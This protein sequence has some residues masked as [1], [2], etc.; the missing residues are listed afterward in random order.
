MI[1]RKIKSVKRYK[2]FS[3]FQWDKFCKN[4]KGDEVILQNFS[5]IF[6]ENGTGKSS[7]CLLLKD[8]SGNKS[9]GD[10]KPEY[11]EIEIKDNSNNVAT[12]L[13][14]NESWAS[15]NIDKHSVLFFDV[16]FVNENIHTHGDRSNH[17]GRHSQNSGQLIIDLDQKANSL[18]QDIFEKKEEL[19]KFE[20]IN[21]RLLNLQLTEKEIKL[22]SIYKD[23]N[24]IQ[25]DEA[26]TQLKPEKKEIEE[27]IFKLEKLNKKYAD[28]AR[29]INI[30][31][32][33][34][35]ESI[36]PKSIYNEIFSREIK[37]KAQEGADIAI[38]KHFEEHKKFIETARLE[39]PDDYVNA[40]CP[41]CMQPLSGA[42]K[43][44][45]FYRNAFDH[46]YE[47]EKKKFV[48]DIESLKDEVGER[49]DSINSLSQGVIDIFNKLE[50][51][52]NDFEIDG[53]YSLEEK[54]LVIKNLD[55][56]KNPPKEFEQ[57]IQGLERLK[58]IEREK[59]D[60]SGLYKISEEFIEKVNTFIQS[61]NELVKSKNKLIDAFKSK[62]SDQAKIKQDMDQKSIKNTELHES[63]IFLDSEKIK[64]RKDQEKLQEDKKI[65]NDA[66]K[67][68]QDEL[69]KHLAEKIPESV[70][71]QMIAIL[72]KFNLNFTLEH[73]KPAP[74]TK[75][76]SFS[77][78]IKDSNG[79][80][81]EMKDGLSEGER[82]LISIA[83]FFA[84]N[85]SIPDKDKKIVVFDDPI[86]S[87]DA[88]NLKILAELI[89]NQTSHF[90][91][92]IVLTHHP[93][94]F[95]YIS[96]CE[97]PNPCKLGIVKNKEEYGGAFMFYDPG[98]DMIE[99]VKKCNQEINE[100]AQKGTLKVEAITLKYGQLLRLT[101]EKFIKN[102]LLMWDK[103]R[104]FP[105]VAN[106]LKSS[107][108]KIMKLSDED[109]ELIKNIYK[110]C[111]YSNLLHFDKE[112]PSALS[113]LMSHIGR[114]SEILNKV[115]K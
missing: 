104:N 72:S 60:V 19:D 12:Y 77:F 103:E 111:D 13:Y 20:K 67:K 53:V 4:S 33:P 90:A 71:N 8:L 50:K 69:T 7:L 93:L 40:D 39:I 48:N 42:V 24:D 6:G 22:F 114:F 15:G 3:D 101:V 78:K 91:Q 46:T 54:T 87:L 9:F 112:S 74:N 108:S 38:K 36:S 45:E 49:S 83:F 2:S 107:K 30:E 110:Y 44:I 1:I 115:N 88:Q 99:E 47:D 55:L 51:L 63:I 17:Y 14:Q 68:L 61:V 97:N 27:S 23:Y 10:T 57:I 41:L 86:T 28:I 82:Q 5:T 26:L 25:K 18:K 96:K 105:E 98:F 43:A 64:D 85:E 76:Y 11:C 70:I 95:K 62:Y 94:F 109:L 21:H 100:E 31:E 58:S 80:E 81:R 52:F 92:V 106:E 35:I 66:L 113:E 102:E 65:L 32:L 79:F 16:D 56:V 37:Q 59:Q 73:I 29:I 89:H 34:L 75:D 84:I